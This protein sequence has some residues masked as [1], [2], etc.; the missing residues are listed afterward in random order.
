MTQATIDTLQSHQA[1]AV[2]EVEQATSLADLRSLTTTHLGKNSL[3]TSASTALKTAAVADKRSLGQAINAYKSAVEAAIES[4]R[5]Q[6]TET[7]GAESSVDPVTEDP[8]LPGL[9][10]RIG[11]LH[12]TTTVIRR[13]NS[14]FRYLGY[15][16]YEGPEIETNEFNF[17]KLNLPED[18]PARELADTLYIS[19][20]EIL[21]R[22]HTS[23]VET[24]AMTQESVPL[25]IV[26]PG[27]VYRNENSNTT[28]NS[29]FYQYEGLAIDKNLS[30]A[31]L[32]GTL[33]RFVQFLYGE[34]VV[35]RFRCKYYP[36]VEPGGG[37]D[38]QCSF[39]HGEG[40]SV[41]KYRGWI[42]V[43]GCGMVHPNV[44]KK[45]G[46]DPR[47]YSGFAFGMGLDRLVMLTYGINDIRKLYNGELMFE[48]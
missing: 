2:A 14:F 16:V 13:I 9:R 34:E 17:E 45:C 27:K 40:C 32:K 22:T 33:N 48:E 4:R 8:T 44:L 26:V 30:M 19:D 37:L 47:E 38:I 12:P 20:P 39:C 5:Q 29:M 28:N 21:L 7:D 43:L 46:I 18:H 42:E 41:C 23:S 6:L 35:T 3:L 11:H 25:R 15:S 36:Q 10:P 1:T 31:D 24:R